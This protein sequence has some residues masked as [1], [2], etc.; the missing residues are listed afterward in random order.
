MTQDA[1]ILKDRAEEHEKAYP[2]RSKNTWMRGKRWRKM[3]SDDAPII[4][5]SSAWMSGS[6]KEEK[7]DNPTVHEADQPIHHDKQ[8]IDTE[9]PPLQSAAKQPLLSIDHGKQ[10]LHHIKTASEEASSSH[11]TPTRTRKK[12]NKKK[13]KNKAC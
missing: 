8:A 1:G 9:W 2:Y 4:A 5:I 13:G 10:P 6:S 11:A 3:Q 7:A 12:V